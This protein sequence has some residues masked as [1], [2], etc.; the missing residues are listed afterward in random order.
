M[1]LRLLLALPLF[2]Q[3]PS[4]G[5]VTVS[6]TPALRLVA[7]ADYPDFAETFKSK[8]DLIKAA[9]K[10]LVSFKEY[11]GPKYV[12]IADRD[13]GPGL[14][15]DSLEEI[16][17]LSKTTMTAEAFNAAIREN[18]DVFQ[19]VGLDG[20]GRVVFSSYYQPQLSASRKKTETHKF[21]L[22]RR[23]ADMVEVDLAALGKGSD[24]VIG[25]VDKDKRVVPYFTRSDIDV[26]KQLAGKG[27][28]IAW[29]KDKF[30]ALDIHIQGSG[31]LKFP[32]GK[33]M[34]AKFAAT[35]AQPFQAV[36]L[37]LVKAGVFAKDEINREKL[38]QYLKEHPEGADWILASNPRY[39]FFDL[40]SLPGDGEPF[41]AL[42]QSLVPSR[43]IACDPA[44][45]PLGA[46]TFFT[47]VS[48]QTDKD[49]KLLGQ[50]PNS[51]FAVCMDTGGAIK[52]PGRIDIYVGH[53]KQAAA[54]APL[55]WNDGKLWVLIKKVPPR[56][57]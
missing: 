20:A 48:P 23:P 1:L 26:R 3:N 47:T 10:A 2:A 14:L 54:M 13:Y 29:L 12:R 6:T 17:R 46:V 19:S 56:E 28:E 42:Q 53:G 11:K 25:R 33:E 36:G 22:Y 5:T 30:D 35:N 31:I 50:F 32:D 55:Q 45:I 34:L 15:A 8:K 39:T 18:F 24:V 40:V 49:G 41:G 27:L 43:S 7:P 52:S 51:R 38:R 16:V 57:R 9:Q 4:T 37:T 21:P 44:A